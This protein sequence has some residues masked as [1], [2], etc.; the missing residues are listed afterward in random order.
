M[1]TLVL[2]VFHE[3]S[4]NVDFFLLHGGIIESSDIDYVL[5]A[6]NVNYRFE[7]KLPSNVTYLIRENRG[8]DFAALVCGSFISRP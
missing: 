4:A 2:Y 7:M 1:K 3:Y 5:I 6:N 8:Y